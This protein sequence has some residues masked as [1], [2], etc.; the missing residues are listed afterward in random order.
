MKGSG[1]R[2]R[3]FARVLFLG[4]VSGMLLLILLLVAAFIRRAP[5]R[6]VACLARFRDS[7][8]YVSLPG[9][10]EAVVPPLEA[11][12]RPCKQPFFAIGE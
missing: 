2:R 3:E 8:D 9:Q 12:R 5:R 1:S 6:Q 10:P 7:R 11:A 4:I